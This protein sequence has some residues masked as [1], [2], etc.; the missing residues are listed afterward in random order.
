MLWLAHGSGRRKAAGNVK[1]L[2][3]N[4]IVTGNVHSELEMIES[5]GYRPTHGV[6]L[7][8][9]RGTPPGQD[10]G[11]SP[12]VRA[13]KVDRFADACAVGKAQLAVFRHAHTLFTTLCQLRRSANGGG[14][15][16]SSIASA[17]TH[18]PS[19]ADNTGGKQQ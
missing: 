9:G 16:C 19:P 7:G 2:I 1:S 14:V 10:G 15:R 4:K 11:S 3:S 12:P 13:A 18:T 5:R 6:C 17:S 8:D